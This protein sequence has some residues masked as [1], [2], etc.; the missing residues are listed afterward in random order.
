M[1]T[2]IILLASPIHFQLSFTILMHI[3]DMGC[4]Q[5]ALNYLLG[6]LGGDYSK[7]VGVIDLGGGSVQMAYAVSANTAAN[8]PVVPEGKDSYITKEYLIGKDYNI[9]VHRFD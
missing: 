4:M 7:T 8:A 9:Y 5:I 3:Y 6:K 1:G 2:N